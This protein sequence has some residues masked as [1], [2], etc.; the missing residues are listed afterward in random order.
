MPQQS[1]HPAHA[2]PPTAHDHPAFSAVLDAQP[3]GD[4]K[5]R[6]SP[7]EREEA[8]AE[9]A[10]RDRPQT[11]LILNPPFFNASGFRSMDRGG[12]GALPVARNSQANELFQRV[13]REILILSS[14]RADSPFSDR[15]YGCTHPGLS[16]SR[17]LRDL[18]VPAQCP[19][20]LRS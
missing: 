20:A 2:A 11:V 1:A 8:P 9:S 10:P 12:K 14:A 17:G 4:A 15:V 16:D 5:A 18:F 6:P 19:Q 7:G 13:S 3:G